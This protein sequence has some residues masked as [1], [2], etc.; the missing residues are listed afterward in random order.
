MRMGDWQSDYDL[1]LKNTAKNL[2]TPM[3]V[4]NQG[5]ASAGDTGKNIIDYYYGKGKYF[6]GNLYNTPFDFYITLPSGFFTE[7]GDAAKPYSLE[8][9]QSALNELLA[10]TSGKASAFEILQTIKNL[11]LPQPQQQSAVVA[12]VPAQQI[13]SKSFK[14]EPWMMAAGL[15]LIL[16]VMRK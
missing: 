13:P 1:L 16:L 2:A 5:P 14:V 15:V 6:W 10:K 4:P 3:L 11:G 12:V 8:L 9:I 7:I